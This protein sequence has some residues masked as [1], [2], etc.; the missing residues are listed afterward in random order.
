MFQTSL[1]HLWGLI[2]SQQNLNY[3]PSMNVNFLALLAL[4]LEKLI[5]VALFDPIP[6]DILYEYFNI[7]D[8]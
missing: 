8:F 4:Y 7:F 6:V 3:L 5:G 1:A 2:I